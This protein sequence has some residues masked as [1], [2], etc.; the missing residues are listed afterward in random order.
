[1]TETVCN[2]ESLKYLLTLYI[3]SLLTHEIEKCI[4]YID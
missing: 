3:K 4:F 2:L 1:M